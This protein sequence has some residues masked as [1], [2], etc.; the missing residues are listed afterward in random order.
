MNKNIRLLVESFFDD[1]IFNN[2]DNIKRDIEDIGN[3]ILQHSIKYLKDPLYYL[4]K[5]NINNL[6]FDLF[7]ILPDNSIKLNT[8]AK[9]P[10]GCYSKF[11]PIIKAIIKIANEKSIENLNLNMFDVS[12]FNNMTALFEFIIVNNIKNIDLSKWDVSNVNDMSRMFEGS[13]ILTV[14]DISNWNVS[15]LNNMDSMFRGSYITCDLSNWNTNNVVNISYM[16]ANIRQCTF[17][18]SKWKLPKCYS[19]NGLFRYI[20]SDAQLDISFIENFDV[21][22]IIYANNV[23]QNYNYKPLN[24]KKWN[25]S[26]FETISYLFYDIKQNIY[27]ISKWNLSNVY[28]CDYLIKEENDLQFI[29]ELKNVNIPNNLILQNSNLIFIF[30]EKLFDESNIF[31]LN[32][33]SNFYNNEGLKKIF[34]G[35]KDMKLKFIRDNDETDDQK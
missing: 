5:Q 21:S 14:A 17:D 27:N 10:K 35:L 7:N 16:F 25:T 34:L 18:F 8:L 30:K 3:D 1:E 13:N 4:N 12:L 23:F 11:K 32:D 2:K 15:S 26:N 24:L 9:T 6:N 29:P 33:L 31:T 22:K 19:I 20:Q 28:K